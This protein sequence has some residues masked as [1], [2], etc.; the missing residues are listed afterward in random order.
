LPLQAVGDDVRV[1][2]ELGL[3][4]LGGGV[5]VVVFALFAQTLR[6]KRFAGVFAGVPTVAVASLLVTTAVKGPAADAVA[7]TGMVAGSVGMVAYAMTAPT[8]LRWWG[9]LRGCVVPLAAWSAVVAA[10]LPGLSA[11]PAAQ[12]VVL[13]PH[14]WHR[15]GPVRRPRLGM[16]PGKLREAG[17]GEIALR[18]GFGAATSVLAGLVSREISPLVGGAFLA[19]PAVLLASLTLVSDEEGQRAARDDARGAVAGSIGMIAFAAVGSVSFN[20]LPT[21]AAFVVAIASWIVVALAAYGLAWL[22]GLGDDEPQQ[23]TS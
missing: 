10:A 13:A 1:I 21:A 3:K 6:P 18:F 5:F 16:D 14:R 4:A 15:P 19:F 8:T 9:T 22:L 2:A 11:A 12:G 7:C 17:M 23:L 20:T